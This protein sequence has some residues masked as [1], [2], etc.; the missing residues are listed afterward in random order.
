MRSNLT[1]E[2]LFV[3]QG[4]LRAS[5]KNFGILELTREMVG[6]GANGEEIRVKTGSEMSSSEKRHESPVSRRSEDGDDIDED[7]EESVQSL[8]VTRADLY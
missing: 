6:K 3:R 2:Y 7:V 5:K 8:E 1:K 4:I